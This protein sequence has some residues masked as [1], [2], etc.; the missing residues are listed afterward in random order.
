MLLLFIIIFISCNKPITK[1]QQFYNGIDSQI[2]NIVDSM[3]TCSKEKPFITIWFSACDDSNYVVRVFNNILM[4]VLPL[5]PAPIM[6]VLI[7]EGDEFAGYKKYGN[8]YLV[9]LED[10]QNIFFDKFVKRDSLSLDEEPFTHF[11]V[12]E[13]NNIY[14]DCD[15]TERMYFINDKD[16]LVLFEG[17]CS[18]QI[19]LNSSKAPIRRIKSMDKIFISFI[20][21]YPDFLIHLLQLQKNV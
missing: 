16:N 18:F 20:L 12:Y 11:K 9:F 10:N 14:K 17:K 19:A 7:S 2:L 15:T 8:T 4:L 1:E 13:W 3:E 5:P 6:E 21:S